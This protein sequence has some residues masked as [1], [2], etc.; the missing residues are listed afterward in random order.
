MREILVSK[1][2][3]SE[4]PIK[5]VAKTLDQLKP[6]ENAIIANVKSSYLTIKLLEMGLLPGKQVSFSF[7]APF[8][9]PIA[10]QINGYSLSLRRDEASLIELV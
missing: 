6:G 9:D 4:T 7:A 3:K 8:G 10:V 2:A 5:P 1:I